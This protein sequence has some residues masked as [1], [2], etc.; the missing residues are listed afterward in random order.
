MLAAPVFACDQ[1]WIMLQGQGSSLVEVTKHDGANGPSRAD[2]CVLAAALKRGWRP[3]GDG[4]RMMG[5]EMEPG[6][7]G[8]LCL[9]W[10]W[11]WL[12]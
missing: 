3:A 1:S 6:L 12:G 4:Q 11:G 10:R 9:G 2:T 5:G 7:A 8:R